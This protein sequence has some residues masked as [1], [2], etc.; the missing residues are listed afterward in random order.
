MLFGE[1]LMERPRREVAP[2][3]YWVPGWL[4]LEQQAWLAARFREWSAGPVPIRG[5]VVNGHEMSV[6]TVCLGWHWRPYQYTREAVD[7]NGNRVLDFPDWMVRLGRKALAEVRSEVGA[8]VGFA[9]ETE[10]G[11]A[12]AEYTPDTALVNYYDDAA[13]MGMHQDRDEVSRAPVV[14]L[15]IGD[16]CRF[17]FGNTENRGQPYQDIDLASGD[18]FVFGGPSRLAYHGIPKVYPGTAPRGCGLDR[19][20]VNITMRVTGLA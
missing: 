1:E 13:R 9:E 4:T 19:G 2:G 6:K 7:V 10:A 16:T 17:R 5:A 12:E 18:L 11:L 15:S 20:R 14:S 8:E 3:A